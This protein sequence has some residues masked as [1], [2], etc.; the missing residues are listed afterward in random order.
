MDICVLV[1]EGTNN[2]AETS[3]SL[4]AVGLTPHIVI[5]RELIAGKYSLHQ[6]NGLVIPG[7]FSAGDYVRSGAIF[8]A[9]LRPLLPDLRSLIADGWPV[10]G[11]CNGFQILVELGV[12]PDC[13]ENDETPGPTAILTRNSSARF[14]CR[15]VSLRC[16]QI[17]LFTRGLKRGEIIELP[18][19][20]AEGRFVTSTKILE[21]ITTTGQVAFRYVG[22]SIPAE[23][24]YNPNGSLDDIAG[25]VNRQGNV[26]GI[27]PHPER[28]F[29]W[30]QQA[31]W[32]RQQEVHHYGP[33]YPFFA[34]M[35]AYIKE[36]E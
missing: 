9:Y 13:K 1:M 28:A 6:F 17:N 27:M 22:P 36:R 12:L 5:I 26:L 34:G 24:P 25:L 2:E 4:A 3:H 16:E 20:H 11:I 31:S 32:P 19:A 30:Y 23:Y 7:G 33:G 29:Y 18:A 35:A 8:A 21:E 15:A 14:E 10:L